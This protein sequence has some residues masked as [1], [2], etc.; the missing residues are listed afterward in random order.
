M[1]TSNLIFLSLMLLF[2]CKSTQKSSSAEM[3]QTE[4]NVTK[5][6]FIPTNTGNYWVYQSL[7]TTEIDTVFVLSKEKTEKGFK[8]DLTDSKWLIP[9]A[10]SIFIRCQGRGGGEFTMPLFLDGNEPATYSTC[11][12]DVVMEVRRTKLSEPQTVQGK[13]YRDCFLFE[14]LPYRK[15]YVAKGIGVIRQIYTDL[16][17]TLRF[18]RQ[19]VNHHIKQ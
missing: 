1:K 10:D 17:G 8:V 9:H 15:V 7:E 12:G 2:G 18:E 5:I 6:D 13:T 16:D 19:L 3:N 11:Q 14:I 4:M